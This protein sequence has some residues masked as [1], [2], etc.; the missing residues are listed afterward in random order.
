MAHREA[1]R[2]ANRRPRGPR[3][4]IEELMYQYAHPP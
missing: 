2:Q 1:A 3:N 4:D